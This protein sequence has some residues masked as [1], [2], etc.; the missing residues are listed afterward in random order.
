MAMKSTIHCFTS[1]PLI[2]CRPAI[3]HLA[4]LQV[5]KVLIVV[6]EKQK[7][8]RKNKAETR[9]PVTDH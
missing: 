9:I 7:G 3:Q 8:E 6:Y 1:S 4:V 5:R 2:Y